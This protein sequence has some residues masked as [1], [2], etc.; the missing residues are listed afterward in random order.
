MTVLLQEM[1][2][3][4]VKAAVDRNA[5]LVLPAGATEQ[6]GP[7]LPLGTDTFLPVE[8]LRRAAERIDLLIAPPLHYG[9]KSRPLSGGGQ[10]FVGTTSLRG[11]TLIDVTR[12]VVAE[13]LRHGF[14]RILV[15]NWHM[16]SSSFLYE[17][18]DLAVREAG[19]TAAVAADAAAGP[20]GIA[21]PPTAGSAPAAGAQVF[22][23]EDAW[24]VF[25]ADELDLLF[26]NGFPGWDSEH[27]AV[28]ETSLMM[29][30]L[31]GLVRREL[32]ADDHSP[33]HPRYDIL[34]PPARI[35]TQTGVLAKASDASD[36]KGRFLV[37]RM[38]DYLV[39]LFAGEF[40]DLVRG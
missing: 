21:V 37:R 9:Y 7:H 38:T 13:Y 2:W 12:D 17:G 10:G 5:A 39:D 34:P 30:L 40:P 26:P 1:T 18:A 22:V 24:P 15:V 11:K 31:P 16:E 28:V 14:R 20:T 19:L 8:L 27:A 23:V 29:T 36:E 3:P 4:E 32:I 33:E 25:T 6:H 35:L